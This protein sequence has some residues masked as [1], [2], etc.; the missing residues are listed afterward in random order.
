MIFAW[1][2]AS[3]KNRERFSTGMPQYARQTAVPCT[4]LEITRGSWVQ[5]EGLVPSGVH[6][7]RGLISRASILGVIIGKNDSEIVMDDG[8]STIN[9]R[10][11]DAK[12]VPV[13]AQVGDIVH[14]IGRPREFYG[15]RYLVLEICK[16]I[17]N[18]A[19]VQ[20]RKHEL[21]CMMSVPAQVAVQPVITE[22]YAE[23]PM[24]QIVVQETAKNPFEL[25]VQKIRELDSGSGVMVDDLL[26]I[27]PESEKFIRT[28]IEEGEIFEIKP[29][30]V[31]VLE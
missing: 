15:Q 9:V 27:V 14:V 1:S 16:K 19:W 20:Y 3:V 18:A 10:S 2:S 4:L 26:G 17:R 30:R 24:Q 5:N 13:Y 25:I 23:Q 28:L 8:T 29:G 6:S 12:P 22:H 31:K 21:E 7:N 11:F